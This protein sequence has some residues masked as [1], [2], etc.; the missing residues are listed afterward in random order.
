M[1]SKEVQ[2]GLVTNMRKWQKIED[3]SVSSTG[4]IIEKT[5]NPLVRIIMEIIQRDSQMHYRVQ[6][7]IADSIELKA[8]S[9]T[10]DELAKLWDMIEHHIDLE[11]KTVE[12][13][14]QA[15][16]ALKGQQ[17]MIVQEYLLSYLLQ[18][19]RKHNDLLSHMDNIMRGMY[20][21]V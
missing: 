20:R 4:Q 12:I 19:E 16:T 10:S 1:T 11:K 8:V 7:F 14:E 5:D 21:S 3:A 2:E 9:L 15:I 6:E 13:A 17:G 18:D